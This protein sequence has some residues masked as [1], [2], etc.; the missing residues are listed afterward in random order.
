MQ[1]Y[2][3]SEPEKRSTVS[4]SL[5]EVWIYTFIGVLHFMLSESLSCCQALQRAIAEARRSRIS[6]SVEF[7]QEVYNRLCAG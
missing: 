4:W 5:S 6:G 3:I 7:V 2:E 1:L